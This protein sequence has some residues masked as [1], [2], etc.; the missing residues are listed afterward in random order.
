VQR[1]LGFVLVVLGLV[2]AVVG[3]AAGCG[4]LFTFS[5]RHP[6]AVAPLVLGTPLRQVIPAQAGR[7]YTLAVQVVF[8][9]AGLEEESG[10]LV[11]KAQLPLVASLE[12]AKV[13][14]TL[15]PDQPPNVL[16]GQ[17]ANPNTRTPRGAGP[18]E[19]MVERLVGPW[20]AT[21]DRNIECAVELGPDRVGRARITDARI[22]VYDDRLP[23]A[24]TASLAAGGGGVIALALGTL[25]VLSRRRRK[26][27]GGA[28]RRP[29]V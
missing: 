13:S 12:T 14:G 2:A 10:A 11:V 20:V 21:S 29:I 28:R 24:I 27:R 3:T 6:I 18:R 8:D 23:R 9:R 25:L 16:Y 4:S 7:R 17:S 19:L 5:G 1:R 15:D 22:I 26:G